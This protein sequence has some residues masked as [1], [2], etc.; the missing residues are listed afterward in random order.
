MSLKKKQRNMNHLH[1]EFMIKK[2]GQHEDPKEVGPL[3]L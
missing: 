3:F 1:H 2:H